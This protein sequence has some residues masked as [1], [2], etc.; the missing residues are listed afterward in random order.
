[1]DGM[2]SYAERLGGKPLKQEPLGPVARELAY[3]GYVLPY[4]KTQ[5]GQT[6]WAVPGIVND[7]VSAAALPGDVYSG[8]TQMA[9]PDGHT[10]DEAIKRS[11]DLAGMLTL[12]SGAIPTEAGTLRMGAK[13][14][15]TRASI[16][17]AVLASRLTRADA[18]NGPPLSAGIYG[19]RGGK[20]ASHYMEAAQDAGFP[21]T[22]E[23]ALRLR[24]DAIAIQ[25]L[26]QQRARGLFGA[27]D[28]LGKVKPE[29]KLEF[30]KQTSQRLA[31]KAA[32][33]ARVQARI[34]SI[35]GIADS[36]LWRKDFADRAIRDARIGA[37]A[38]EAQKA[39][40]EAIPRL[41]KSDGWSLRH[42]STS[43]S[44]RKSSR[45]LVSPDGKF[46]VRLSDHYLPETPQRSYS[47]ETSGP[48]WNDEVVLDGFEDPRDIIARIKE[49]Y[50]SY[51]NDE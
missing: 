31:K 30:A 4:G 45:Y 35:Q 27:E 49:S 37:G 33:D 24:D 42:A 18:G 50:M 26:R 15:G 2:S 3:R 11:F 39:N 41:M 7:M 34:D 29:Q 51:L 48:R 1:M 17:D 20:K 6:Q 43:N 23:D 22:P 40:L 19:A 46:E 16:D 25:E 32:E 28:R 38:S 47:R 14:P 13:A 9:G 21:V 8:K 5:D 12:G 44:G 36:G 10:S